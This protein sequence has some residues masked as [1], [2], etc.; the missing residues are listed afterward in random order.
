M[1]ITTLS[2]ELLEQRHTAAEYLRWVRELIKLVQ[3]EDNGIE[4]IRLR[5]GLA[6]ELMNEAFPIGLLAETFF[7]A[8][9]QVQI[10]LR[11]GSQNFDAE[12]IDGRAQESSVKYIEVTTAGEGEQD[13]LRMLALHEQ[14][15]ISG[16]G[17]V[18][19]TG[20]KKTKRT[21]T[22]AKDVTSQGEVLAR[23]RAS[24]LAAI[25]RKL[26]KPYPT[27]T[28]LLLAFDDRMAFDRADNRTNLEEVLISLAPKLGHFH[29]VALV[30]LQCGM[31]LYQRTEQVA[32]EYL[33]DYKAQ[34]ATR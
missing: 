14:G 23:E 24:V 6:K 34:P 25:E 19:K 16:L 12:V 5:Q 8:S 1:S 3:L 27:G 32:P 30:G 31:F 2:P 17:K 9:E 18:T 26:D 22:V 7:E 11:I 20:T 15:Q 13:Y 21:V 10:S 4:R 29:S 33:P 28:L